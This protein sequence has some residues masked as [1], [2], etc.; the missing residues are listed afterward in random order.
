MDRYPDWLNQ[1][2][3]DLEWAIHSFNGNFFAQTCFSAQQAAENTLKALCFY[4]GFDVVRTHSLFQIVTALKPIPI[5][6]QYA[7]ELDLYY[8]SGRYPDAF[9]AGA[10]F[11]MIT[12]EQAERALAAAKN[13]IAWVEKELAT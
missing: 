9:P 1:A 11:E 8:I 5:I 3:N 4:R 12:R 2:R 10:P 13:I 7:K 6:E